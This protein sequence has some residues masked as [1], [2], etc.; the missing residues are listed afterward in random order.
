MRGWRGFAVESHLDVLAQEEGAHVGGRG[1]GVGLQEL[2]GSLGL[3]LALLA[4][5]ELQQGLEH[6]QTVVDGAQAEQGGGGG[7]GDQG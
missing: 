6:V 4:L 2:A 3:L 5:P 7:I 1:G